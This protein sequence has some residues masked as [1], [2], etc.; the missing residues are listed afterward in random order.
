[1]KFWFDTVI[2]KYLNYDTFSKDLFAVF[3]S[4]FWLT[5]WSRDSNIYLV[6]SMFFS[7]PTSLLASIKVS[8]FFFIVS[9][10]SASRFKSSAQARSWWWVLQTLWKYCTILPSSLSYRLPWSLWIVDVLSH[11]TPIFSPVSDECRKSD[12]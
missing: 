1:M 7:R 5:F 3:M 9:M 8:V 4:W 10:L 6:F 12:Q 11:C 2:P